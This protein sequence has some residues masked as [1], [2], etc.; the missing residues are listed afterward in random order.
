MCLSSPRGARDETPVGQASAKAAPAKMDH[1]RQQAPPDM[2]VSKRETQEPTT[3]SLQREELKVHYGYVCQRGYYPQ[4]GDAW[5]CQDQCVVKER[6]GEGAYGDQ[7]YIGVFD[8]HGKPGEGDVSSLMCK[9]QMHKKLAEEMEVD[10][11]LSHSS[12]AF[13][14]E[15]TAWVRA[16]RA[17]NATVMK[18]MGAKANS[19]GSTAVVAV[20]S[21]QMIQVGNLGDSRG[22][23]GRVDDNRGSLRVIELTEDQTPHRED[24]RK[25]LQ[26]CGAIVEISTYETKK[27]RKTF[28]SFADMC[29][30]ANH[31]DPLRVYVKGAMAPGLALSRSIGDAIGK[32]LGVCADPE[33][34]RHPISSRDKVAIFFSDGVCEYMTNEEVLALVMKHSPDPHKAAAAVV[35]EAYSRWQKKELRVD[36]I[37]CVVAF[38]DRKRKTVVTTD[39]WGNQLSVESRS[40]SPPVS[41]R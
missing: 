21:A 1:V 29:S 35:E 2:D 41:R 18:Q 27:G 11:H 17:M 33:F 38:L 16:F 36:D 40:V 28:Q 31:L 39:P 13:T 19:A 5:T 14:Q 26:A 24:E 4:Y 32:K 6:F 25:R 22:I 12:N 34:L 3:V 20:L 23:I 37:T 8:G 9:E 30:S 7:L 10:E 15:T